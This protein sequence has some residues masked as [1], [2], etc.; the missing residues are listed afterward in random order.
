METVSALEPPDP[1]DPDEPS[2]DELQALKLSAPATAKTIAAFVNRENFLVI[3]AP[4][5]PVWCEEG[6]RPVTKKNGPL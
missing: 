6:T 2:S 4:G 5:C 3:G 1:F